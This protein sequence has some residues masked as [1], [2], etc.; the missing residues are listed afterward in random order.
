[1]NSQA[2]TIFRINVRP[3][4]HIIGAY[5]RY[6]KRTNTN[7]VCEAPYN[8]DPAPLIEEMKKRNI[9]GAF[10]VAFEHDPRLLELIDVKSEMAKECDVVGFITQKNG[11]ITGH[12]Q[13]YVGLFESI[14]RY[15]DIARKKV[16]IMG[17]GKLTRTFCYE[18]MRK[19]IPL[20]GIEIYNRTL[21]KAE[22]IARKYTCVTKTGPL[23]EL[24]LAHGDIF[25]NL[26]DV[27]IAWQQGDTYSFTEDF[28]K[29]F[30]LV[31]DP[32]FVPLKTQLVTTAEKV[33]VPVSPGYETF[34]EQTAYSLETML[35][36]S[37]NKKILEEEFIHEFTH[38]NR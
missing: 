18:A 29:Q 12:A 28:V 16:I 20:A 9:P 1:M 31:L 8:T 32:N 7:V 27:G 34:T 22:E 4:N 11:V 6:F 15:L 21:Q 26:S 33:G 35:D 38:W 5:N 36:I 30:Q 17:A 13:G 14:K 3:N 23:S 2:Q 24:T 10:T 19:K 37:I 25:M